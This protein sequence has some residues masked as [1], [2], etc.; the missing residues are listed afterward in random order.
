MAK[1]ANENL[2]IAKPNG[3]FSICV[4][5]DLSTAFETIDCFL[6]EILS[7][8]TSMHHWLWFSSFSKVFPPQ[9]TQRLLFSAFF[10]KAGGLSY[11][12]W[13]DT[14]HIHIYSP[15]PSPALLSSTSDYFLGTFLGVPHTHIKLK[16]FITELI[17]SLSP[18]PARLP[19]S[20]AQLPALMTLRTSL[21]PKVILDSSYLS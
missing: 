21:R 4:F 3:V 16:M 9:S 13:A 17:I 18:P 11:H 6:H 19:V 14:S 5:L 7:P 10:F 2:Y 8:L 12:L 15:V 20:P 1:I